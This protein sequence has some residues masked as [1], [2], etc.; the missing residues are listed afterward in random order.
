M[1]QRSQ[2]FLF[3]LSFF[4]V[5]FSILR[6]VD[7]KILALQLISNPLTAEETAGSASSAPSSHRPV[8]FSHIG[9]VFH[10][11]RAKRCRRSQ[12]SKAGRREGRRSL[13]IG[14]EAGEV[15]FDGAGGP[16]GTNGPGLR[17]G[18]ASFNQDST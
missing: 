2:L 13:E 12:T 1:T 3:C 7:F 6:V 15:L 10:R 17:F 14:M 11:H 16:G 4:P 5:V 8:H 18:C 9:D